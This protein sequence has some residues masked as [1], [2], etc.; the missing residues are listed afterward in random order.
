MAGSGT[1]VQVASLRGHR[2]VALDVDPLAVLLTKVS[3]A[4][5][6]E[7]RFDQLTVRLLESAQKLRMQDIELPW[8]DSETNSFIRYWFAPPQRR[9]LTKLASVLY[10]HPSFRDG[11]IEADA[12]RIAISRLIITKERGASLG[13]DVSHSRPHRVSE[14]N[15]FD[16]FRELEASARRIK[17]R[18]AEMDHGKRPTVRLAD[19]RALPWIRDSSIDMIMTSPPYL[20]AI[21]YMRGHRLSLVWFG[22]S[23]V[24]LRQIRSNSI[25]AERALHTPA[26]G[27]LKEVRSALGKVDKLP[28]RFQRIV[29][30]YVFDLV[31]IMK[32]SARVLKKDGSAVFV[33]GNSCLRGVYISNARALE[34][35]AESAG[36]RLRSELERELPASQRYLPLPADE[37]TALGRRMRTETVMTFAHRKKRAA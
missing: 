10:T 30:R 4:R 9:A 3:T 13:R 11:S 21:D 33:I 31:S 5:L 19:A 37:E 12:L 24:Q 23:L 27:V 1:V 20:N 35:A 26:L 36:L 6:D 32:Q 8:L 16:V 29:D 15:D 14:E 28:I 2:C 17:K 22:Y 18:L 34:V 25:G 7:E